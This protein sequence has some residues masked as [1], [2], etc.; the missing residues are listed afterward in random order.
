MKRL[1]SVITVGLAGILMSANISSRANDTPRLSPLT[2]EQ[3]T[4]DQNALADE[5]LKVSGVGLGGPYNPLLRSPDMGKRMFDLLDYLRWKT[6]VPKRLNEFAI[7]IVGRQWR[8]QVEWYSHGPLAAK[9]GLA[10]H[11]IDELR[12]NKRPTA[13]QP[14]EE[15]VYNFVT[16]LLMKYKVSDATYAR[17]KATL[18]EQGVVDLTAVTGTYVTVAMLI[19]AAEERVPPGR[20]EP[21]KA[22]DP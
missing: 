12:A 8:S 15:V 17:A 4:P 13:M 7:L 19:A 14:D 18:G 5:I 22:S 1:R 6:S 20:E 11:T 10:Q 2:R 3:M 9:A 16:E 21:F